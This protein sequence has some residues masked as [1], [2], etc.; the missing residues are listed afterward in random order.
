MK[1]VP[2]VPYKENVNLLQFDI[3]KSLSEDEVLWNIERYDQLF[4]I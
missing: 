2:I 4:S 3:F 1:N